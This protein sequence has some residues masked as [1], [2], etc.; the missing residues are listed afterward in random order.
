MTDNFNFPLITTRGFE[1]TEPCNIY[2]GYKHYFN[3]LLNRIINMFEWE[4]MPESVNIPFLNQCL[5]INGKIAFFENEGELVALNGNYSDMQNLYYIPKRII[6]TNP[7]LKIQKNLIIGENC[8]VMYNSDSDIYNFTTDCGGL[9]TL[10]GRTA[11]L[12]A[13]SE[14]SINTVQKNNRLIMFVT[15]ENEQQKRSADKAI[16]QMYA[17][18]TD[19]TATDNLV[20][21]IKVTPIKATIGNELQQLTETQQ[22]ILAQFY[23][24]VG[25][26]SNY[27]MKRER[28]ITS[29]IDSNNQLLQINIKNMLENRKKACDDINKIFK[30]D[31]SV[32]LSEEWDK[33]DINN[34]PTIHK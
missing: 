21:N 12:L 26:D 6:V 10:I 16:E 32:K 11:H 27:N 22:Y 4:N 3:L 30:C 8:I 28:L 15:A 5:F 25:I 19:I 14:C 29:E 17:G 31:I 20:S 23:N 2:N 34:E 18:K 33:E 9:F 1:L 24:A 13:D 7:Q